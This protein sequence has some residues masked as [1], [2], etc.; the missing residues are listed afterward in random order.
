[1]FRSEK[2]TVERYS[3]GVSFLKGKKYEEAIRFF[4][5]LIRCDRDDLNAY[6]LLANA[7][8][9]QGMV[10][11]FLG[12][13]Q[14]AG[15]FFEKALS[16]IEK[17]FKLFKLTNEDENDLHHFLDEVYS[18]RGYALYL[19]AKS[20]NAIQFLLKG[21]QK[22]DISKQTRSKLGEI[23]LLLGEKEKALNI[24]EKNIKNYPDFGKAFFNMGCYYLQEKQYLY[25]SKY[26]RQAIVKNLENGQKYNKDI[27][28]LVEA[29]L[30]VVA[31]KLEEKGETSDA[32]KARQVLE[33][34]I[35]ALPYVNKA[36]CFE[37]EH[38][39]NAAILAYEA[40]LNKNPGNPQLIPV[41]LKLINLLK[42]TNPEK[43]IEL[44]SQIK[45]IKLSNSTYG[46]FYDALNFFGNFFEINDHVDLS[47]E[48]RKM[49][50]ESENSRPDQKL[51]A[52]K[53]LDNM[54]LK[55]SDNA[56]KNPPFWIE[57]R[58]KITPDN[59]NILDDTSLDYNF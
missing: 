26:F 55:L 49:V 18:S 32:L 25:A 56:M 54:T 28:N 48:A 38:N 58:K 35:L 30:S 31:N 43:I 6:R 40:A 27:D 41:Y 12:K 39:Y 3:E 22:N 37:K 4:S 45:N 14:E 46:K 51:F 47:M 11:V 34:P 42:S 19:L 29:F 33:D 24:F 17:I 59:N 13:H 2:Y 36:Y 53:K 5:D 9:K 10:F 21:I 15:D 7:F 20:D 1:M 16:E 23:Y 52:Q 8:Y 57:N 50:L 44:Y